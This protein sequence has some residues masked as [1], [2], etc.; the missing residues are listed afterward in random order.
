MTRKKTSHKANRCESRRNC[1]MTDHNVDSQFYPEG[2]PLRI[3]TSFVCIKLHNSKTPPKN[4][5]INKNEL[6]YS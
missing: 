1:L 4:I 5:R 6:F 2:V 3:T